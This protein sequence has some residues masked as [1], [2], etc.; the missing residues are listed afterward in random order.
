MDNFGKLASLSKAYISILER[1]SNPRNN[2]PVIPSI[3]TLRAIAQAMNM[4]LNELINLLDD[5]QKIK[6]SE[7]EI[8]EGFSPPPEMVL[9]PLV[10]KI[11]CGTPILAEQNIEDYINVP[12]DVKCDFLLTC[13]GDSMI[14]AGIRS[15]DVVYLIKQP[16]IDYNGQ[17]AAVRVDGEATLKKVFKYQDKVVL[18]P[19]NANYEPLVYIK[20]EINDLV[21]EGIA[22]GFTHIF[23]N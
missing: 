5:N 23:I 7:N 3:D 9:K 4:D 14:D 16:D 11:A 18:Q 17:I 21:I 20:E 22:T 6:L 8:P 19:A 1:G 12:K 15:G 13:D 10:G 2:K